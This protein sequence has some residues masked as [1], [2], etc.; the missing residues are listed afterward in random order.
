MV[1]TRSPNRDT[2]RAEGEAMSNSGPS[3]LTRI[4]IDVRYALYGLGIG[5]V[6][7]IVR[8]V[9][10]GL[11]GS[12]AYQVTYVTAMLLSPTAVGYVIGLIRRAVGQN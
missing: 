9:E 4:R 11:S 10:H 8:I 5:I 2:R 12:T 7:L 3:W 6:N 1:K